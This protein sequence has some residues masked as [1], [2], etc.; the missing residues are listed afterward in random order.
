M[1]APSCLF[2]FGVRFEVE[3]TELALLEAKTHPLMLKAHEAGLGH[4]WHDFGTSED[5]YYLFVGRKLAVI[6]VEGELGARFDA[7]KLL[8]EAEEIG[9]KLKQADLPGDPT[10]W[11]R[12]QP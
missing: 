2:F 1:S 3:R 4:Y 8:D 7:D 6:G 12:W 10:F 11:L 9:A 5:R